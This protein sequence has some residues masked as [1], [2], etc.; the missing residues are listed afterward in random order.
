MTK[1][2][3]ITGGEGFIGRNLKYYI[4]NMGYEVKSLDIEGNPDYKISITDFNS[5]MSI[6][7]DFY[8]V[9]HLAATTAPPQFDDDPISGFHNNADGTLNILEYA[10][11]KNIHRVIIASSSS[12]YGNSNSISIENEIPDHYNNI[13]PITKIVDE[14]LAK[15]YSSMN[16]LECVSLRYFN[17]YGNGE[18]TKG[19]Y[20]SPVS[21]FL[22]AALKGEAIIVYGD[23]SQRRDFIYIKDNVRA[24][25]LAYL[26]GKSGESYNVGTG[27]STSYNDIAKMVKEV[28]GSSSD[29][30]HIP[31]P[32]KSYQMFTQADLTK[33]SRDL[34]FTPQYSIKNALKEM[35]MP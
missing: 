13:Y 4:S 16:Y 6:S 1:K 30:I 11:R 18:N 23:G 17:T 28:T 22:E 10:K 3:L 24:T 25:W 34:Q 31:N 5:L 8:A 19:A 14:Y 26:K 7:E 15:Y 33:T 21:K 20:S 27:I 32:L 9:F 35:M 29:I 12:V 2:F